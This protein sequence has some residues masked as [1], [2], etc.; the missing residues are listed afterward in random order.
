MALEVNEIAV[1]MQVCGDDDLPRSMRGDDDDESGAA[2]PR[3]DIV[4]ADPRAD[5]VAACVRQV[6]RILQST[7]ER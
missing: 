4:A 7:R 3:A 1:R 6:I 2:D 5:I